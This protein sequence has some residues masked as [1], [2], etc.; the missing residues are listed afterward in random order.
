VNWDEVTALAT[1][2]LAIGVPP[3][4]W[5]AFRANRAAQDDLTATRGAATAAETAA[6]RQIEAS[7]RPLLAD[8]IRKGPVTDDMEAFN[9]AGR[10]R[11]NI[12]IGDQN[13]DIDPRIVWVT[14]TPE[15]TYFSVPMRNVGNGLAVINEHD[16]SVL[17]A[18]CINEVQIRRPRVPPGETTRITCVFTADVPGAVESLLVN[19]PYTD[20]DE[21]QQLAASILIR[22]TSDGLWKVDSV[23]QN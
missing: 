1:V 19:I 17:G 4:V 10:W 5:A 21:G 16:V 9:A 7:F 20:F 15:H 8:V 6:H 14:T 13:L 23:K 22:R 2:V 11:I 3:A 12:E 18:R